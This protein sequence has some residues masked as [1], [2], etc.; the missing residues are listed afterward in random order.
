[1]VILVNSSSKLQ[2]LVT[3][4]SSKGA[5]TSSKTHIGAGLVKKTANI[6]DK[7]VKACLAIKPPDRISEISQEHCR[8]LK[9]SPTISCGYSR[10]RQQET[11]IERFREQAE[12]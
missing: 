10:D 9:Q 12:N 5:S 11:D 4:A 6:R 1:M 3:L 8:K 2:N 7:A